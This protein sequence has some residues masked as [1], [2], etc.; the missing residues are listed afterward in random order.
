MSEIFACGTEGGGRPLVARAAEVV[1]NSECVVLPRTRSSGVRLDTFSAPGGAVWA[2]RATPA[3]SAPPV[4]GGA[5]PE[6]MRSARGPGQRGGHPPPSPRPSGRG[7][8]AG[9]ARPASL[10]WTWAR[11]AGAVALRV[12]DDA[13]APAVLER[14]GPW[15]SPGRTAQGCPPPAR[16]R[17]PRTCS[18]T[19]CRSTSTTSPRPVEE[20][21]ED[22]TGH[23]LHH[24]RL[25]GGDAG[26]LRHGAI[27][28]QRLREV[29]PR[30][31]AA[32]S[33]STAADHLAASLR[34][35]GTAVPTR[36]AQRAVLAR[37]RRRRPRGTVKNVPSRNRRGARWRGGS[38]LAGSAV[39]T[40]RPTPATETPRRVATSDEELITAMVW[41]GPS[42]DARPVD[43]VRDRNHRHEP[44]W[45]ARVR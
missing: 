16:R 17:R 31:T 21:A 15:R 37:Q 5:H 36:T 42:Q 40:G 29:V 20:P 43:Q 4:L 35:A 44:R 28:L 24:R 9:A 11:R 1:A 8:D 33:S 26:V 25:H 7:P 3:R 19:G 2:P 41:D 13:A 6:V 34:V 18:R 22:G 27:P 45:V 23:R 30:S 10:G 32:G 12:P 39:R 38:R 14:V